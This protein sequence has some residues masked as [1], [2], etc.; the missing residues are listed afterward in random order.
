LDFLKFIERHLYIEVLTNTSGEVEAKRFISLVMIPEEKLEIFFNT[1]LGEPED[2][3][4][5]YNLILAAQSLSEMKRHK[6]KREDEIVEEFIDKVY[7]K[8][9]Y[10]EI[11]E[12]I[13]SKS[14]DRVIIL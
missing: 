14:K 10:S 4:G 13:K 9:D 6:I 1:I 12:D 3:Y 11:L 8:R 5:D 2:E 7:F